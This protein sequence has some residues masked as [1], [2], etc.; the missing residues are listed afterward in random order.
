[1]RHNYFFLFD[2][3][4]TPGCVALSTTTIPILKMALPKKR[5][6]ISDSFVWLQVIPTFSVIGFGTGIPSNIKRLKVAVACV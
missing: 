4:F 5:M 3:F 2:N 1:V 6:F